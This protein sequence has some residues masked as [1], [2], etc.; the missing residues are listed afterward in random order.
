MAHL[1][2]QDSFC[3]DVL[4]A[5]FI[6]V[7]NDE[8][9][10]PLPFQAG[11][12]PSE[13]PRNAYELIK[14]ELTFYLQNRRDASAAPASDDDLQ[15]EACRIIYASEVRAKTGL[16]S[17]TSWLRDLFMSSDKL[18]FRAQMDPLRSQ[19]EN[20]MSQLRVIGKDSIFEG[21]PTEMK[22][23]E[24]VKART[25]LGLTTT[26]GELQVEACDI[27]GRME[28]ASAM[29]SEEIANF[30]LRL[31]HKDSSWLTSFRQRAGLPATGAS[32]PSGEKHSMALTIHNDSEL[33]KGLA[34]FVRNQ[35]ARA[36]VDPSDDL[37][38]KL[39]RQIVYQDQDT[40]Q[41]TAADN[42]EWLTAFKRRHLQGQS[43][44][45]RSGTND[46]PSPVVGPLVSSSGNSL[47]D[48]S[49]PMST[50]NSARGTPLFGSI[51]TGSAATPPSANY[52][53]WRHWFVNGSDCYRQLARELGRFVA[54]A[55]SPNNP[56]QH[57]PTDRELQHQARWILFD[58]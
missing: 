27:V 51:G 47:D 10:T 42:A 54:S 15:Y 17:Q 32:S 24:F 53:K 55:T 25:M 50:G 29:P 13:S 21:C 34:E 43:P 41:Q 31:I 57:V 14:L 37:L 9:N 45:K 7:I 49:K 8:R 19:T 4:L 35:R 18:S 1:Q 2:C 30:L 5:C 20:F 12:Q 6:D 36:G 16:A 39:S 33:E 56:N 3:T 48:V 38:R 11:R 44:Q 58:E 40:C 28:E 26:D 52:A 22:L 23:A 46:L